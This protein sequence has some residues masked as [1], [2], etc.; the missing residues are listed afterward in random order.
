MICV[1]IQW[2]R[3]RSLPVALSMSFRI[4]AGSERRAVQLAG[5]TANKI[6]M[7]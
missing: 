7:H 4:R 3:T 2:L 1:A 6:V 5:G